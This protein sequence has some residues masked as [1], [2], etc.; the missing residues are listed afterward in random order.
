M[1]GGFE[2]SKD[3]EY[4]G[5]S[6]CFVCARKYAAEMQAEID[7][8]TRENADLRARLV[9]A[10]AEVKA[11]RVPIVG[12][13]STTGIGESDRLAAIINARVATDADPVLRSMIE[14]KG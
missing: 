4:V 8:L 5:F 11:L 7:Q 14:G 13:E 2:C 12:H 1:I 3:D 10:A 6:H 9:L